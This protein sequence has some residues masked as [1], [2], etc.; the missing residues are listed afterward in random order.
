MKIELWYI[1]K[2]SFPYLREGIPIYEK[3]LQRY[4]GFEK[5]LIPDVKHAKNMNP[6]VLKDKE[7][8]LVLKKLKKDDHLILLD[9]KGKEFTS[10]GLAV[11][12][13]KKLEFSSKRLIFL[14]GGAYGFSQEIYQRSNSKIALSKMTFSHQMI[15]LFA[16]EQLYRAMTIIKGDPYHNS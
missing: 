12:L 8:Q 1:G 7:G 10:E 2:T 5:V 6:S 9:E 16:I 3:R 14:I 13:E 11:F 4:I 15:R